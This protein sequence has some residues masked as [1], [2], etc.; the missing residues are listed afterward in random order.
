MKPMEIASQDKAMYYEP[1]PS[2]NS[3]AN[4]DKSSMKD[5]NSVINTT[6]ETIVMNPDMG[7]VMKHPDVP[8][9]PSEHEMDTHG[10]VTTQGTPMMKEDGMEGSEKYPE[11]PKVPPRKQVW[12][13]DLVYKDP[14]SDQAA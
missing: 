14:L 12:F 1:K 5:D 10:T 6:L 13:G 8:A 9:M 3:P 4:E 2:E 7:E 11:G